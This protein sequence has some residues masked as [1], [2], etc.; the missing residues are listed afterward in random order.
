MNHEEK[1]RDELFADPEEV[2]AFAQAYYATEFPNDER[3]GCPT[4]ES[5]RKVA[6][7]G[8]PPDESLRSHLFICSECFRT[9]R[10]AR[11]TRPAQAA[12]S[13]RLWDRLSARFVHFRSPWVPIAAGA[14][15]LLF[16]G[17]ITAALLRYGHTDS[18]AV[19]ANYSPHGISPA[20]QPA[21]VDT[22]AASGEPELSPRGPKQ[23]HPA[24]KLPPLATKAVPKRSHTQPPLQVVDIDLKEDDLLRGDNEAGPGRRVITLSPKR[25]R[26]RLRMPHGSVA[27]RYTVKVVDAYGKPL[28]T[29]GAK[30]SGKTLNV[31]LDLS[32]LA[33][34]LYRLCLSRADEAPDCYLMSV[35]DKSAS[36]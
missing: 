19:A 21:A 8:T 14:S 1:N 13:G 34:K 17:M 36:P 26:L 27:G 7:S 12:P 6:H 28:L 35:S 30:S 23:G 9:F 33:A 5:L 16:F 15:C 32:R 31:E 4:A 11:M 29:V 10:S 24:S 20:S 25:Q 22:G 2:V 3:R 18:P